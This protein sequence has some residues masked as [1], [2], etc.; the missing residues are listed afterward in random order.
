MKYTAEQKAEIGK[1]AAENGV[2]SAIRY[3]SKN[4]KYPNLKES[5]VRDWRNAYTR[6]LKMKCRE[7][8]ESKPVV[9]ELVQKKRGRPLLLGNELDEYVKTYLHFVREKGGVVNTAITIACA[10]G[11]IINHDSN[12]LTCNGGPISLTKDWGKYLL[13]RMG[14]VK[15][16][17]TTKAKVTVEHFENVKAQ[18]LFDIKAIVEIEEVP[19]ALVINWDQTGINYVPVSSW[20][21]AKEGSKRVEIFGLD[22]KRQITGVFGCNMEGDFL[23]IQIVYKGKTAKCLPKFSFPSDWHITYSTNHWSNESTMID[24]IQR[25]LLPYIQTKRK[26]LKL[27]HDHR[28]LVIYDRFKGQCTLDIMELLEQNN[29]DVVFVL[30]NCTDRLQPLD[31]SVNK[32]AKNFLRGQFQKWYSSQVCQQ[33]QNS[34][35]E[36]EPIDLRLSVVK[37]LGAKW[38]V[39]MYD[40]FKSQPDI[41]KN[42]FKGAGITDYL[43]VAV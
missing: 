27:S 20:T 21:M 4:S 33:L 38:L 2:V 17:A 41:I 29:I 42:G 11:I 6:E 22:D 25:I 36:K 35:A 24:Y 40:Y 39:D 10:E 32:A 19:P 16:K 28:A 43:S 37:P 8:N 26:E 9:T 3:F 23:P 18:F 7:S 13:Q 34:E 1:R 31:V 15:R 5:S 14:L 30:A 12:L